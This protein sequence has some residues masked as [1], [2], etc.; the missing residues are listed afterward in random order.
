MSMCRLIIAVCLFGSIFYAAAR[1]L[2]DLVPGDT[3]GQVALAQNLL[4]LDSF[5]ELI[6][7]VVLEQLKP[8]YTSQHN[9]GR[10]SKVTSGVAVRGKWFAPH[11]EKKTKNEND[12][13]W[14]RF[15][16]TLVE[17]D[18]NLHTRLDQVT[19]AADGRMAMVM[20]VEARLTGKGQF[21]RWKDGAK[22][23]VVSAEADSTVTA[24][25]E[26]EVGIRREPGTLVDD[27]VLDPRVTAIQLQVVDLDLHRVGKLGHD[28][29]R[30]LGEALRPTIAR[31]LERREP[32]IV[33]KA[34]AS[35]D[36]RRARLRFSPDEFIASGWSKFETAIAG[37]PAPG[38]VQK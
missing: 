8:E 37:A 19:Q 35:I 12:G 13:L 5:Q 31:E 36:K 30:E 11:L 38:T 28:I 22:L 26:C 33:A 23:L 7:Q 20:L 4:D 27:I 1:A 18:K 3:A 10:Q 14:Q 34:N 9:W 21:E 25:V 32:K 17:P 16:V 29:S 6:R 15:T 2:Q 24:R